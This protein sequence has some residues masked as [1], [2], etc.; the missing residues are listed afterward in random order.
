MMKCQ[1]CDEWGAIGLNLYP[2]EDGRFQG[3][4]K[5]KYLCK[6]CQKPAEPMEP[7]EPEHPF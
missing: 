6:E 7:E 5:Y 4:P 1:Q 3:K 2:V